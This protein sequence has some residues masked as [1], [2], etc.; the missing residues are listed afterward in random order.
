M[1]TLVGVLAV[2]S[3]R[4]DQ[5]REEQLASSVVKLGADFFSEFTSW[6]DL[7]DGMQEA[8]QL[9][10]DSL[11]MP[12]H[13]LPSTGEVEGP[14]LEP[15]MAMAGVAAN[16]TKA[17]LGFLVSPISLRNPALTT[18]MITTLDHISHGRAVL[19]IGG[20]WAEEEYRQYGA[21][22]GNS[23][24]QR[25]EWLEEALPMISGMLKGTRPSPT[26]PRWNMRDVVNSPPPVQQN[27]PILIGGAGKKVTL[28][29]VAKYADMCNMIGPADAIADRDQ[30]LIAHCETVGRDPNEIERTVGIR[31]PIIRDSKSEAE[32]VLHETFAHHQAK[33]LTGMGHAGTVSDIVG[34]CNDYISIG[35]RHLIFQF[36]SPFDDETLTRLATEVRTQLPN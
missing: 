6:D 25:L 1:C 27:L 22:F 26:G 10:Y 29:L 9:G 36:L 13:V 23:P 16:T 3:V 28:R 8:E 21:D 24:G 15:Y 33:H 18:K 19:G 30:I 35:Y 17:S 2:R 31:Q 4:S 11:W 5:L 12:D 20:G 7:L 32:K 34:L 14:I